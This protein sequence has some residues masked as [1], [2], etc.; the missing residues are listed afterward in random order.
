MSWL[1]SLGNQPVGTGGGLP[2]IKNDKI[3]R[4]NRITERLGI[5]SRIDSTRKR[6]AMQA[7]LALV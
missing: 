5:G 1:V 4:M 3:L 2:Q 7:I 6:I